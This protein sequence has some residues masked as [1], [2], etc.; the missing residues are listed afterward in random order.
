VIFVN[1]SHDL[2]HQTFDKPNV[3]GLVAKNNLE[4]LIE[5]GITCVKSCKLLHS[6]VLKLL[7]QHMHT[8]HLQCDDHSCVV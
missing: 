4:N 1:Q 6:F 7:F 2:T 8:D 5:G 3:L